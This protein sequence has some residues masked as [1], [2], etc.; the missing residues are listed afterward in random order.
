MQAHVIYDVPSMVYSMFAPMIFANSHLSQTLLPH[1][2]F[3]TTFFMLVEF[4][5]RFLALSSFDTDIFAK[6]TSAPI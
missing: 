5:P 2:H 4:C 1:G 6:G 3:A